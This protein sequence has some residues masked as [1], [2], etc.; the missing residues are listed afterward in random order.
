MIWNALGMSGN[1]VDISMQNFM[2][3][4]IFTLTF[5]A[6]SAQTMHEQ[7]QTRTHTH[8]IQKCNAS[9]NLIYLQWKDKGWNSI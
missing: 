2:V 4:K 3:A 1:G 5:Y 9:I 8:N 7:I 6:K